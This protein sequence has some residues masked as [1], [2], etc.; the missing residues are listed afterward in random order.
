MKKVVIA[1]VA[2]AL[3]GFGAL[4]AA[5]PGNAA[6]EPQQATSQIIV[7]FRDNGAA[8]NVLRQQGLSAGAA[9]GSTGAH[10][11]RVPAGQETSLMAALSRNPA[12]EYAEPDEVV[13]ATTAD[14]YSPASTHCRTPGSR[15]PTQR[16]ISP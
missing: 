10:V 4:T 8:A 13:T 14:T 11:V 9:I 15:L 3:L 2:A 5:G 7:K 6:T 1:S 12:V 16:A